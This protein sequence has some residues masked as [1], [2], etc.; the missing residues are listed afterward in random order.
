MTNQSDRLFL[1]VV[2]VFGAA[3]TAAG[4]R[5]LSSGR[6]VIREGGARVGVGGGLPRPVPQANA[7]VAGVIGANDALYYPLCGA[8]IALGV[9]MV[10][11]AALS[12]FTSS[13][14]YRK[15]AA[16]SCLVVLLLG[17]GTVAAALWSGP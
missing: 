6:I 9:S 13:V 1:L 16:Y 11:L 4:I 10:A 8:W 7:R 5:W 2:L 15:L 14:L 17:F 3:G 12:F